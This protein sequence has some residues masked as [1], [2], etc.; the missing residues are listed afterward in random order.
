MTRIHTID[1]VRSKSVQS[2][3]GCAWPGL[4]TGSILSGPEWNIGEGVCFHSRIHSLRVLGRLSL[5]DCRAAAGS[6]ISCF[7]HNDCDVVLSVNFGGIKLWTDDGN[8]ELRSGQSAVIPRGV[9]YGWS[10]GA[11]GSFFLM[12]FMPGGIEHLLDA[13]R[14]IARCEIADIASTY[15]SILEP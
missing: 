15:G 4:V 11:D 1:P 3:H 2:L 5:I 14:H 10:A 8:A 6:S 13:I 12:T 7:M 9:K